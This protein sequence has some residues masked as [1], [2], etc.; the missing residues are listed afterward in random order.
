LARA[1]LETAP[2]VYRQLNQAILKRSTSTTLGTSA[3]SLEERFEPLLSHEI[4]AAAKV[5]G[6]IIVREWRGFAENW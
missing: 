2:I 1:Y 5:R 6:E 3:A 4:T